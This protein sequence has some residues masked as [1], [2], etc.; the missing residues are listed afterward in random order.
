VHRFAGAHEIASLF[1]DLIPHGEGGVADT[2]DL[3]LHLKL[4]AYFKRLEV[5]GF[6]M[7]NHK[8]KF[9]VMDHLFKRDSFG[10]EHVFPCVVDETELP[11]KVEDSRHVCV[12]H[13]HLILSFEHPLIPFFEWTMEECRGRGVFYSMLKLL[14]EKGELE[15]EVPLSK[16]ALLHAYR[17][18]KLTRHFEERM[19]ILQRQG[20]ISFSMSSLGEE[21]CA[22]GVALALSKEDWVY[23]QYRE[24]GLLFAR[25]ATAEAYAHQ[26]FCNGLDPKKGRQMPNHF[27]SRA[28]NI[29]TV[30]SPIGTKIPHAAGAAYGMKLEGQG[31]LAC[32]MFGEGATS[33]G[34]FH[35]GMN[36]ASVYQVPCLFFCRNN[37]YAISTTT[38]HQF[39]SEGIAPKAVGYGME[40][41]VV[42]GNDLFAVYVAV[43]EAANSM[44]KGGGPVLIEAM[45]YR[46]GAHST[47]D[48]P[49][50]YRSEEEVAGARKK[51][52]IQRLY[53]Y[54]TQAGLWDEA[55]EKEL[56]EEIEAEVTA[57]IA[58]AKSAP[59]P[60]PESLIE[61]VYAEIPE[62]LEQQLWQR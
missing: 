37:G 48:D 31:Q 8:E 40:A 42:D 51:D 53:L 54:L 36:F 28:L 27:G 62:K 46:L 7:D 39:H 13:P 32:V 10:F 59:P 58:A 5:V 14:N 2:H 22:V 11:R 12:V 56:D 23:P 33:E 43:K 3:D 34:D 61:D 16:E 4:I 20:Q 18:C 38:D 35:A 47:S 57:A 17:S 30:S 55:K 21:A 6:G 15:G 60:A 49:S 44:R 26:M 45:T 50:A 9:F 1:E 24:A 19:L 29:V 25:G 41:K 52:P